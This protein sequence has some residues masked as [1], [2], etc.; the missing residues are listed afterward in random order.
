MAHT[1]GVENAVLV[2]HFASQEDEHPTAS[3]ASRLAHPCP[4]KLSKKHPTAPH[5]TRPQGHFSPG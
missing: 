5:Q 3:S 2:I 1:Q 4:R